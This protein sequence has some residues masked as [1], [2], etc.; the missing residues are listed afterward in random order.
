MFAVALACGNAFI[1]KPSEKD[2]SAPLRLAE[3][4]AEAGLP[5]GLFSVVNGDADAVDALIEDPRV[6]AISFVGSSDV[7]H[8]VYAKAARHGKRV[9]AFGGAKN[10]VVVMPDADIAS[11]ANQLIGSAFGSAGERCMATPVAVPVGAATAEVLIAHLKPRVEALRIGPSLSDDAEMGPLVTSAHRDRV[12]AYI[13]MAIGE[14]QALLVDGRDFRLQ[15][16]EGGFFLGGALLDGARPGMKSYTDE[17]FGPVLQIA[18]ARD[19]DEAIGLAS[20]HQ[21]GNGAAIFTRSGAAAREFVRRVEAGMVG[22]NAAIPAP[23]A[24]HSFGGWKRSSFGDV[25]QHGPEGVR[26]WTRVK[27][28]TERWPVDPDGADFVIPTMR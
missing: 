22:V 9:Q 20:R 18:R 3:L 13:E 21:Y 6:A 25:N 7:A 26:F 14:G 23:V 17:I 28:V 19:L 10:H 5:D 2:P 15:G 16:Y 8:A 1:L 27:T 4:L 24:Y 11:A 12:R